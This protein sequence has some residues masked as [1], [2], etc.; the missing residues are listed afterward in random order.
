MKTEQGGNFENLQGRYVYLLSPVRYVTDDQK[1]VIA[2]HAKKLEEAGAVLFNPVDDAPQEDPTGYN[3]VMKELN[4]LHEAAKN[5]G[6]V[7]ILWNSGG[8]P[9]EGS[10]VDMG[11]AWS[12]GLET[13]IVD[14][15]NAENKTGPTLCMQ[16]LAG[17]HGD[18]IKKTIENMRNCDRVIVD[19]DMEM[20]SEMQEWQRIY[21]G[22]A[23]GQMIQNPNIKIILE[24]VIGI[25]P[26]E[27]KSY[28]K[29]MREIMKRQSSEA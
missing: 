28:V 18:V 19:W 12:L 6:R 10:R 21:L 26:P 24:K 4:F 29:A 16:I 5:G 25:D 15:F 11:I 1:I 9:S 2:E 27:K 7:D 22:L 14:I 8:T 13:N 23:L 20:K 17:L 3:I